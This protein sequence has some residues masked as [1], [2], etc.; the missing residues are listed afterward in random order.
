MVLHHRRGDGNRRYHPELEQ[1]VAAL[2][3][4]LVADRLACKL[5]DRFAVPWQ[6]T[7]V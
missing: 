5:L 1:G 4:A 6:R 7:G 3:L 2:V